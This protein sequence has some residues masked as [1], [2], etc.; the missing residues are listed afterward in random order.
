M[1]PRLSKDPLTNARTAGGFIKA[2]S[3]LPRKLRREGDSPIT[4]RGSAI[5][6]SETETGAFAGRALASVAR[7]QLKQRR[8]IY[9][10]LTRGAHHRGAASMCI[11]DRA[12]VSAR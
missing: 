10:Q 3:S 2:L 6:V 12:A 1:H 11:R 4:Q 7:C 9:V 5:H 8:G